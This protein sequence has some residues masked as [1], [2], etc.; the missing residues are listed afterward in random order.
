VYRTGSG[1]S[2]LSAIL[3][4]EFALVASGV[5]DIGNL[6][7][8]EDESKSV[9]AHWFAD[10]YLAAG[11]ILD[12]GWREQSMFADL[13]AQCSFLTTEEDKPLTHETAKRVLDRY[14]DALL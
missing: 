12:P 3:D 8:F 5:I 11:G 1:K 4:W 10:A 7:R 9:T 13:L 14:L 6:L 2:R